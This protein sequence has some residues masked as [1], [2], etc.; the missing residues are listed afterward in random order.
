ML[1]VD[2][3][4]SMCLAVGGLVVVGFSFVVVV[5]D[6]Q[7]HGRKKAA[8]WI[9]GLAGWRQVWD[10]FLWWWKGDVLTVIARS[11]GLVRWAN[12]GPGCSGLFLLIVLIHDFH[13]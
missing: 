8:G 1:A 13:G 6:W 3:G 7:W 9:L 5:V 12:R 4:C 11:R 10:L 2:G